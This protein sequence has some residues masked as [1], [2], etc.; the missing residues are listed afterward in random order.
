MICAVDELLLRLRS[1]VL[2]ETVAVLLSTALFARLAATCT[3]TSMVGRCAEP[4]A[5]RSC[6]SPGCRWQSVNA[7]P[8]AWLCVTRL[9]PAGSR[10]ASDTFCPAVWPAL[11]HAQDVGRVVA[12]HDTARA[13]LDDR[14]IIRR[15]DGRDVAAR[16][17]GFVDFPAASYGGRVSQAYRCAVPATFTV[18]VRVA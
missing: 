13:T 16:I 3:V 12:R 11:L 9:S 2:E 14:Q 4:T 18:S 10:S 17:V 6:R 1:C 8:L 5:W 15:C 7:G